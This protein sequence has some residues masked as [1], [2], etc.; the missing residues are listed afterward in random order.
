MI[1]PSDTTLRFF[2][3]SISTG[4]GELIIGAPG[5]SFTSN[6]HPAE[7]AFMIFM[8]G[9]DGWSETETVRLDSTDVEMTSKNSTSVRY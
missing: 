4:G 5:L 6:S 8:H 1:A 7:G 3:A 9:N 2:G